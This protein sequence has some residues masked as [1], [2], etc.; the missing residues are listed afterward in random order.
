MDLSTGEGRPIF[1]IETLSPRSERTRRFAEYW[2]SLPKDGLVPRRSDFDPTAVPDLLPR[3]IMHEMVDRKRLHLRLVGTALVERYGMDIT[4]R[5]YLEF[6]PGERRPIALSAMLKAIDQPAG[7]LVYMNIKTVAGRVCLAESLGL[8]LTQGP[9]KPT[10]ILFH[11]DEIENYGHHPKSDHQ[12]K[13][14]AVSQRHYLD[15]GNGVPDPDPNEQFVRV[16]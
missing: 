4:G 14:F 12:L 8:P 2:S 11:S 16:E 9:E 3:M 5:D 15:L 10:I 1:D 6:V 7:M 13:H